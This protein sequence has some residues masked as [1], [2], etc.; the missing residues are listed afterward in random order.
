M[1]T[2]L[3]QLQ[4]DAELIDVMC[5]SLYPGAP[6]EACTLVLS[7]CRATKIDPMLKP[8]HLVPI[9]D[10]TIKGNRLVI[11]P[12]IGLYRIQ[13]A[14]TGQYAGMD[15][16]VFGPDRTMTEQVKKT[17]WTNNQ[18][19]ES[20][21]DRTVTFPE[22]CA[23]TAYRIVGGQRVAFTAVEY[24]VENYA[25]SSK[26]S[27]APN[28]MWAKRP[29]GQIGKCAEAQVLRKAFPEVGSQPSAEE[30]EGRHD[31]EW[32]DVQPPAPVPTPARP[33]RASETVPLAESVD[34]DR[35]FEDATVKAAPP[36]PPSPPAPP[37][38][39]QGGSSST[40]PPAGEP[41]GESRGEPATAGECMNVIK[42]AN[43]KRISLSNLLAE[44]GFGHLNPD[45]LTG[46]TKA[47]FKILKGKL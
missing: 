46:M 42:T 34:P 11:M 41:A 30:M 37:A 16:P 22:W 38:H 33:R 40:S 44:V 5:A 18:K 23:V 31:H 28:D 2:D 45:T 24:W 6:R 10:K 19:D 15:Q 21:V 35:P 32:S 14:R 13:A 27:D 4:T 9:Y 17:V 3:A 8:V 1:N 39:E 12:G 26:D 20:W 7:Y 36:P 25:T 47:E 43:A 29:R